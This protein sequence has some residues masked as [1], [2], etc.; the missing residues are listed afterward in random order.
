MGVENIKLKIDFPSTCFSSQKG[1]QYQRSPIAT[2]LRLT[3]ILNKG[4]TLAGMLSRLVSTRSFRVNHSFIQETLKCLSIET[5]G[6]M[7]MVST[8]I[9]P[10]IMYIKQDILPSD[11]IEVASVK[12]KASLYIVIEKHLYQKGLSTPY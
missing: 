8:R 1:R 6:D 4:N 12:R 2:I 11:Q 9:Y 5:L 3:H 10:M 7:I